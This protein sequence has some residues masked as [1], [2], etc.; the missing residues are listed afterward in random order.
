MDDLTSSIDYAN[1]QTMFPSIDHG[2]DSGP[3]F[4]SFIDPSLL[5]DFTA[6]TDVALGQDPS[7]FTFDNIHGSDWAT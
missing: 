5:R 2:L 1:F 6:E 7:A 3:L 4:A